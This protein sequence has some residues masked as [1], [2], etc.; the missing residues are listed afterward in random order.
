MESEMKRDKRGYWKPVD[1]IKYQPLFKW[2]LD[3]KKILK[4]FFAIPGFFWPWNTFYFL[5]AFTT[6]YFL[7][8]TI[9]Q[10]INFNISLFIFLTIEGP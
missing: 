6:W 2:P 3:L 1:K 5:L 10:C 8:P 4:Y 9:S 7:S